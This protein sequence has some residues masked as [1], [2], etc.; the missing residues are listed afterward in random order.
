MVIIAQLCTYIKNYWI[1]H[2]NWASFVVYKAYL[3]K[4]VKNKRALQRPAHSA[5]GMR[6]WVSSCSAAA[7]TGMPRKA[8]EAAPLPGAIALKTPLTSCAGPI[9]QSW[10]A[11]NKEQKQ[12]S[13]QKL[14]SRRK[15]I[16]IYLAEIKHICQS[17]MN[18]RELNIVLLWRWK[19]TLLAELY[20]LGLTNSWAAQMFEWTWTICPISNTNIKVYSLFCE[21]SY[22]FMNCHYLQMV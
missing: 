4:V 9:S 13:H 12:A 19:D 3:N 10:N 17:I 21:L 5:A 11:K 6:V 16:F 8:Q 1:V 22:D 7:Q 14:A 18:V 2:L 15:L 20:F